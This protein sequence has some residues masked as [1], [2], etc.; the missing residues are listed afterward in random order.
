MGFFNHTLLKRRVVDPVVKPA[1]TNING[2]YKLKSEI[3]AITRQTMINS[4]TEYM[5]ECLAQPRYNFK[6]ST[7]YVDLPRLNYYVD[8]VPVT[9]AGNHEAS[10]CNFFRAVSTPNRWWIQEKIASISTFL[11]QSIF[12]DIHRSNFEW[13]CNRGKPWYIALLNLDSNNTSINFFIQSTGEIKFI[14]VANVHTV[15][16]T[17][18]TNKITNR[19]TSQ[20]NIQYT[21]RIVTDHRECCTLRPVNN[22]ADKLEL[23]LDFN[24]VKD[25]DEIKIYRL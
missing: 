20:V 12:V 3:N 19:A 10:L 16:F 7:M 8:N 13:K 17:D 22:G 9:V 21:F 2:Q 14:C 23:T 15:T 5:D 6:N 1:P 24:G 18:G 25:P 11:H 4:I